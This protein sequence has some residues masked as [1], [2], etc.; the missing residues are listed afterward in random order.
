M[1]SHNLQAGRQQRSPGHGIALKPFPSCSSTHLPDYAPSS[2][3]PPFNDPILRRTPSK[4]R[5]RAI[6]SVLVP[7]IATS[8]FCAIWLSLLRRDLDNAVKIGYRHE[9]VVNYFWFVIGVFVLGVSKYGLAG[10]EAA[11]LKTPF[12]QLPNAA[13]LL[14]HSENSWSSPSGWWKG[15]RGMWTMR[16]ENQ[17]CFTRA[18]WFLLAFLSLISFVAIPLSGLCIELSDGYVRSSHPATVIGRT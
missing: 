14:M 18:L 9:Q 4:Y 3:Q 15:I 11:M 13:A 8:C 5:K 7:L 17:P 1:S 12:W 16:K 2:S 10:L 6:L